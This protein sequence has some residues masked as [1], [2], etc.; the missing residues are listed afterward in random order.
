[1]NWSRTE[2]TKVYRASHLTAGG[3]ADLLWDLQGLFLIG[4]YILSS[5]T[6]GGVVK[7]SSLSLASETSHIP[8]SGNIEHSEALSGKPTRHLDEHK[9][10]KSLSI[11]V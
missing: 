6:P 5:L 8:E 10:H 9:S 7:T 2:R 4:L 1:M 11:H 3:A